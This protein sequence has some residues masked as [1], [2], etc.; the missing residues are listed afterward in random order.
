MT[1][2]KNNPPQW[3]AQ[4]GHDRKLHD[5]IADLPDP[6]AVRELVEAG[7]QVPDPEED[8]FCDAGCGRLEL[9]RQETPWI[10]DKFK[11]TK[12]WFARLEAALAKL[13]VPSDV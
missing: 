4:C 9:F 8:G 2:P 13:V 7:R 5:H 12:C 1:T 11:H 3:C 6:E 10:A